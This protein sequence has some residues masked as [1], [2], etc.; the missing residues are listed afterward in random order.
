MKR[1]ALKRRTPLR[2]KAVALAA[3]SDSGSSVVKERIQALLRDIVIKRDGG[4]ILRHFE[5]AGAC[6]GRRNDGELILQAEHLV[7][8]ANSLSFADLRNIVCLCRHHHGDWKP[9]HSRLYWELIERYIG[10]ERWAW[11]KVVE[12][13]KKAYRF[14]ESDWL[15]VEAYLTSLLRSNKIELLRL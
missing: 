1:T 4:C 14:F 10:P 13:D 6:G 7:T 2:R 5:E 8:R 3:H 15:K 11:I 9:Q 12:A